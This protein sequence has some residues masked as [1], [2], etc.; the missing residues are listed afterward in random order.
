MRERGVHPGYTSRIRES[1]VHPW[2]TRREA[3]RCTYCTVHGR[4]TGRH[5]QG[6]IPTYKQQQGG[7]YR[8]VY[9][10]YTHQGAYME[11]STILYTRE[12][13]KEGFHHIIH[14]GVPQGVRTVYTPPGCTAGCEN[15]GLYPPGCTLGGEERC[16]PTRAYPRE[17]SGLYL[18]GCTLGRTVVYIPT[19]V[20]LRGEQWC[21][22]PPGCT[23]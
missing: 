7:I 16:I 10:P 8:E 21:I 13:Y 22:Y 4:H 11:V 20:Y 5:T 15:R 12:A 23:P 19:R 2:Y 17:N 6:G 14:Q 9:L 18:P 1:V 3:T